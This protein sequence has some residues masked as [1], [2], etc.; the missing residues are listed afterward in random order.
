MSIKLNLGVES[1]S[2]PEENHLKG[3]QLG[4]VAKVAL[5]VLAAV[6]TVGTA[7]LTT[8]VILGALPLSILMISSL[9]LGILFAAEIIPRLHPYLPEK[10]QNIL[11]KIGAI[12]LEL[13]ELPLFIAQFPFSQ[14]RND[15]KNPVKGERPI[16][17][18]HGYLHNSSAWLYTRYHYNKAGYNNVFTVDLGH[19][20][21]SIEDYAAVVRKRVQ[22][23]K[24]KTGTHEIDLVCHSMGGLAGGFYATELAAKDGITVTNL[25]TL[26]SPLQGTHI[27]VIGIGK[28]AKEMRRES[29]FTEKLSAQLKE[30]S[31]KRLHLGSKADFVITPFSSS[32]NGDEGELFDDIGHLGF[33]YSDKVINRTLSH[34]KSSHRSVQEV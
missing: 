25:V 30:S 11:N 26:G 15:P 6:A 14:M 16:L 29:P 5:H 10:T 1:P 3:V 31:I 9:A 13:V 21:Q 8:A 33:L 24:E 22:E 19:P 32:Q 27:S 12:A 34:L 2:P 17:L 18:I 28:C 20:F 23:I 4:R 7:A